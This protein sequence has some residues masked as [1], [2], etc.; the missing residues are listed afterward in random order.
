MEQKTTS[1]L[2]INDTRSNLM[3]GNAQ[4]DIRMIKRSRHSSHSCSGKH[5][6]TNS[7]CSRSRAA[8]STR[9]SRS[10]VNDGSQTTPRKNTAKVSSHS[11]EVVRARET[12]KIYTHTKIIDFKRQEKQRSAYGSAKTLGP[13]SST[14]KNRS[15]S[16][17]SHNSGS[18]N[19]SLDRKSLSQSRSNKAAR[20]RRSRGKS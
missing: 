2:S 17:R 6:K 15:R 3:R 10:R 11:Q 7:V 9:K 5:V 12:P 14:L 16:R 20:R 1:N 19:K 13:K 8:G 18:H 4:T